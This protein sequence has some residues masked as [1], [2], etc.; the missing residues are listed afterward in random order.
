MRALADRHGVHRRTVWQAF[1]NAVQP[2]RKVPARAAPKLDPAK[3]LIDAMLPD[4]LTAP[5]KQRHTARRVPAR[6][7]D[8]YDLTDLTYSAVRDHVA[9]RRPEILAAADKALEQACVPQTHELG[10][11]ARWTSLICGSTCRGSVPSATCSR[12]GCR[13]RARRSIG[14]IPPRRR[15]RSWGA[16]GGFR[17]LRGD[18][19][20]PHPL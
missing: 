1:G 4:D 17:G 19:D 13:S 6:L 8:E 7:V 18:P 11:E 14:P 20:G 12:C 2:E 5:R 9:K 16:S 10:A 15:R 3:T